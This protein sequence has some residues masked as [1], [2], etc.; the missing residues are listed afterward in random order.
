M[1]NS[2]WVEIENLP[3]ADDRVDIIISN[4]VINLSPDKKRVFQEAFRVLKPGGRLMVSD[5]VLLKQLPEGFKNSITAYL[6]CVAGAISKEGYLRAIRE[7]G[8]QE[9]RILGEETFPV[10]LFANDPTAEEIVQSLKLS[11]EKAKDS[12]KSVAGLKV[13]AVKPVAMQLHS[14]TPSP[15]R[16]EGGPDENYLAPLG[17]ST[18]SIDNF[19]KQESRS[20]EEIFLGRL[21]DPFHK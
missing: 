18:I 15:A 6:G 4:C 14:K 13:S 12:A 20:F 17:H 8:F 5:I 16:G 3:V 19:S 21:D 2:G 11:R 9:T 1:S 7:A 10:E